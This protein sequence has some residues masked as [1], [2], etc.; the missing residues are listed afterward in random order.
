MSPG[1][2][3]LALV[4]L[5]GLGIVFR[6]ISLDGKIY[7]HDEAYTSLRAAGYL[8]SEVDAALFQNQAIAAPSLQRFQTIKP[9]STVADTVRSLAVDVPQHPP[10]YF[11]LTRIWM[12]A[13]GGS[14][15]ATRSLA[16]VISLFSLPAIY[17]LGAELFQSRFVGAIAAVLLALSPF[18]I[19]FAETSRQ[20]SLQTLLILLSSWLLLRACRQRY[21]WLWGGYALMVAAGLYTQPL[22]VLTWAAHGLYLLGR[23][24]LEPAR[25]TFA[26]LKYGSRWQPLW[27]YGIAMAIAWLLFAPW[28]WVMVTNAGQMAATSSWTSSAM[29]LERLA[30]FWLLS[31]TSLFIDLDFGFENP[32]TFVLRLPF[33]AFILGSFYIL[34]RRT[35]WAVWGFIVIM[36]VLP[37]L[38]LAL[39]D[40]LLGGYRSAITRYLNPCFPA[41]QLAVAYWLAQDFVLSKVQ[42]R[43]LVLPVLLTVSIVSNTLSSRA[44]SWWSKDLSYPN[45]AIAAIL[46]Q[47]QPVVLISDV[48]DTLTNRGDLL[49][50]SHDLEEGVSLFLVTQPPDLS[51]LDLDQEPLYVF[52]PSQEL[53]AV[54]AAQGTLTVIEQTGDNLLR[55]EPE[56]P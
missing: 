47:A 28:L 29:D 6:L 41:V 52:R 33:L 19:L 34:Y 54:L 37:F 14:P 13:F 42:G 35:A 38:A 56:A 27:G 5:L 3:K 46:N 49:G 12:Q 17:F 32:L 2:L 45:A 43:R 44:D 1:W 53:A 22:I 16:A 48:G 31:F 21:R 55:F 8:G 51:A 26:R 4:V 50:L 10:L 23:C 15:T 24:G 30:K 36:A 40:V 39:P 25:G 7:W 11:V 20:Y 18:D 9:G